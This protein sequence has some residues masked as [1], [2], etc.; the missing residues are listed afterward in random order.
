LD[1]NVLE[2]LTLNPLDEQSEIQSSEP[3]EEVARSKWR[4]TQEAFDKL[5]AHFSSDREEAGRAYR[6]I[7]LKLVRFFEWRG[8]AF[9]ED[10]ADET[11]NRAAKKL[12]EGQDIDNV[13]AY[14]YGVA[15]NVLLEALK[16]QNRT[17]TTLDELPP[18]AIQAV[19]EKE[20]DPKWICFDS[21]I[22]GLAIES[23][24]LILSYYQEEQRKKIQLRQ[25]LASSLRIPLNALRIRAH[26]IRLNLEQCIKKC[27]H[28]KT[29]EMNWTSGH[30]T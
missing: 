5:L 15:R 17:Q 23:R 14:I 13:A 29:G 21:C 10:R 2:F 25:Q 27:L 1:L 22:E 16:E 3:G 12:E 4:L 20:S 8:I 6:A 26:R 30:I 24:Y 19:S 11:I 9:S 18:K 28:T 7:H